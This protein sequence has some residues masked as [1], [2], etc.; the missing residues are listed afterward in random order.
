M[1]FFIKNK[2]KQPKTNKNQKNPS[3]KRK[4]PNNNEKTKSYNV[5]ASKDDDIT[6]SEDED[7]NNKE[8]EH[9]ESEDDNETAQEKKL[10]LAKVYLKEIEAQDE[11]QDEQDDHDRKIQQRLFYDHLKQTGRFRSS[12]ADQYKSHSKISFLKAKEHKSTITCVCVSSDDKYLYSGSKDGGIVK[13]SL[14]T[15]QKLSSLPFIKKS[16]EKAYTKGHSSSILS[17]ALSHDSLFLAVGDTSSNIQIWNPET[18]KHIKTLSGH[19]N[20]IYALVFRRGTHTLYSASADRSV[21]VWSL[22][23]MSYVETLYGHLDAVTAIDALARERA[24]TAGGRDTSLRMWKIPEE[25]QLIYNGDTGS[26]DVVKLVNEETFVSGGDNGT[27]SLWGVN[28]KKPTASIKSAHGI[29]ETNDQ[30]LWITALA[31]LVNTDL[32]ASG[33]YD[34]N[35]KLWKVGDHSKTLTHLMTIPVLGYV[36]SLAF[37]NDGSKLIA[38]VGSEHRLGRWNVVKSAKNSLVVIELVKS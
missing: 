17:L 28:K 13:W 23:E 36:N 16:V 11:E 5:P 9:Y 2:G 37:S 3:R 32:V 25:S 21:K 19:K 1:S 15:H 34:G 7:F 14:E 26:I 35:I 6:S 33:S 22:D 18:F 38:A 10:R 4:L 27:L 30:P 20:S 12:V 24:V 31:A 8:Q 29:D